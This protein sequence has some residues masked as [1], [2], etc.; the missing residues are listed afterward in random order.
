MFG[1][2]AADPR[3]RV[4]A[5]R[6]RCIALAVAL[7]TGDHPW[8]HEGRGPLTL[9]DV[10]DGVRTLDDVIRYADALEAAGDWIDI[11]SGRT[12]AWRPHVHRTPKGVRWTPWSG[13][14][15][16]WIEI[17]PTRISWSTGSEKPSQFIGSAVVAAVGLDRADGVHIVHDRHEE[18]AARRRAA[19]Q[20]G[21]NPFV[22]PEPPV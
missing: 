11:A 13:G 10:P 9:P 21:H 6:V 1:F 19:T 3:G 16:R 7:A 2:V 15:E 12:D 8:L 4:R 22:D 20:M 18:A 5:P 14:R 17:E